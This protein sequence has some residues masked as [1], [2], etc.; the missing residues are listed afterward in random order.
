MDRYTGKDIDVSRGDTVIINV[1]G[2]PFADLISPRKIKGS[3]K[4][5]FVL[6][7]MKKNQGGNN[8]LTMGQVQKEL[9]KVVHGM[10]FIKEHSGFVLGI[11][12]DRPV[13]QQLK[14]NLPEKVFLVCKENLADYFGLSFAKRVEF[15][16]PRERGSADET[17][18]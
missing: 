4:P 10:S 13:S 16:L 14:E 15:V 18:K 8:P 3:Q 17:E 12:T 6:G 2:A 9:D 5:F 11:I 7:Q 1:Q